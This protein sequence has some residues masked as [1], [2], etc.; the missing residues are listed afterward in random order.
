[1]KS[2]P[3]ALIFDFDGLIIDSETAHEQ[4]WRETFDH[5]GHALPSGFLDAS[6]GTADHHIDPLVHLGELCGATFN[7]EEARLF[8]GRRWMEAIHKLTPLP[9]VIERLQEAKNL[10]VALAIASSSTQTWIFM[11]LHRL[12]LLSY[13]DAIATGNE[14]KRTKPDPA[15]Y[16][17]ALEKLGI[18]ASNAVALEDS[19]H[20]IAAARAAGLR[21]VAVPNSRTDKMNLSAATRKIPSLNNITVSQLLAL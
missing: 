7:R 4:A 21:V 8:R 6:I 1:M 13:F 17:L 9:G 20:G 11:L 5:Y 19:V 18:A 14:V 2:A 15:L 12:D 16:L 10:G 3:S